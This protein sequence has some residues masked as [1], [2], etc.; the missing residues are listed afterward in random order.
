MMTTQDVRN[1]FLGLEFSTLQVLERKV[2]EGQYH[3]G[4]ASVVQAI[5]TKYVTK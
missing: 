2:I 4:L 1:E 5:G 3:N